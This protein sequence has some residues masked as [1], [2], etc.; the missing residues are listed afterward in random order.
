MTKIIFKKYSPNK[1]DG[2][3][4]YLVG[5]KCMTL[6]SDLVILGTVFYGILCAH[7]FWWYLGQI[8]IIFGANM[9][10]IW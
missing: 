9:H 5:K 7:L 10:Y 6:I 1:Y 3:L 4:K 8:Y 2:N